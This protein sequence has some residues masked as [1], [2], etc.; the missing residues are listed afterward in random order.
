MLADGPEVSALAL[1]LADPAITETAT[2]TGATACIA[3]P[4]A[5]TGAKALSA[6][7]PRLSGIATVRQRE[8]AAA[9]INSGPNNCEKSPAQ[10]RRTFLFWEYPGTE[11]N[12]TCMRI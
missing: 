12:R 2:M 3:E 10:S 7:V 5:L 8:S 9:A 1:M 4:K 6:A 11:R